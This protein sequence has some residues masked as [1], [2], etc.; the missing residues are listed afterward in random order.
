MSNCRYLINSCIHQTYD[1]LDFRTTQSSK[2]RS[3]YVRCQN[4]FD[5]T[6]DGENGGNR[7][8][9]IL[10]AGGGIGRLVLA[11]AAKHEGFEVQ[12]FE[13]DLSAVRGEGQH[14]G[15]I[16]LVSSALEVLEA[17]DENVAKQIKEA[18]CVTGN[19]TTGYADGLSGEWIIKFDLS[20]PAVSRGLPLT[21]V[22][23]RMALQDILL[24][25]VGLDIV[26]NKSK[27]VDF[28]EDPSKVTVILEDGQQYD[29][30]VLVGADGIWSK[31]R[32]KLFGEREAKYSTYT[33]Y[34]GVTNFV[35]PYI[36]SVAYRIF[37]GL[38]QCFVAT[39][40]GNGKIQWFANHKEQPMS[41]DPPEGKKKRLLE[42]F[43]NWCPEVVTLIQKTP[44]SM[45]L[46]RD[47]YDR[48][49]I[50]TWGAGRVTLL[51]DAA[52][53]MQPNLG[54]GGCMAIED[55]YQLIHELVQASESD[56]NVQISEEIV[57]ALR[58]YANKRLWR[59]GLVFAASRFA[60]KMLASYKPYIEFK[61]GPLAHL[62]T[63]QITHPAIP[64]FRAFLQICLPKFMAWITAG[65]G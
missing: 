11:L 5:Q 63:Q 47:I 55:C 7:K 9:K 64:V 44:E 10:I 28:L 46:R 52:H 32:A 26:R 35:P 51:G 61:I 25:A 29:G 24:N 60:S 15:P 57:L 1:I 2:T 41:N 42:K 31:V 40:V 4:S 14:R 17:I 48:D 16:Q 20:S 59:V 38:N 34:S 12:V 43:G 45:I 13:K 56:S 33:S 22:I 49:M 3:Y 21:L 36:D 65:H 27:V 54:Q 50:Y 19:R 8:L 6:L 37:L 53:P 18:G 23:C 30:E 39:D 62:L 58:R